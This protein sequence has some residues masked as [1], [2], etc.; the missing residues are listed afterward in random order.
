MGMHV[1]VFRHKI[2]PDFK[3]EYDELYARMATVVR[4]LKG[5]LSHKVFSAEDGEQVLIGYFADYE[6]IDEWDK[7][8]EHKFASRLTACRGLSKGVRSACTLRRSYVAL[9]MA[10]LLDVDHRAKELLS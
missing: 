4:G 5:Y 2:A 10:V 6:A 9:G 1:E 7:H 3:G 8:P